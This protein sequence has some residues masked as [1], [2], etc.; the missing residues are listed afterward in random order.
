MLTL[1]AHNLEMDEKRLTDA[2]VCERERERERERENFP[3]LIKH[4]ITKRLSTSNVE[5]SLVV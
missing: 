2:R 4:H 1:I 5:M 3:H